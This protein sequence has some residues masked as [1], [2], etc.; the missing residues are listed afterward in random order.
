MKKIF[1]VKKLPNYKHFEQ[2]STH[3][4]LYKEWNSLEFEWESSWERKKSSNGNFSMSSNSSDYVS[5]IFA[6]EQ[7]SFDIDQIH[8]VVNRRQSCKYIPYSGKFECIGHVTVTSLFR[9]SENLN[10]KSTCRKGDFS[11]KKK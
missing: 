11:N 1:Y 5:L 3:S 7:N 4:N 6:W 2:V 10:F 9:K 8:N